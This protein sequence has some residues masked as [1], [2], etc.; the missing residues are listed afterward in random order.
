MRLYEAWYMLFQRH[1]KDL[2]VLMGKKVE[3][4]EII[5]GIITTM[6]Y[7]LIDEFFGADV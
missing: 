7:E 6:I 1:R 2:C 5:D 3:V 4:N